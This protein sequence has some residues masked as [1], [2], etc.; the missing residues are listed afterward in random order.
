MADLAPCLG[1]VALA[2]RH[3]YGSVD[4]LRAVEVDV[5]LLPRNL[6]VENR[7]SARALEAVVGAAD[8]EDMAR[9]KGL[10]AYAEADCYV[11]D[12]FQDGHTGLQ[13]AEA[14]K[15]RLAYRQERHQQVPRSV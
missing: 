4:G 3:G 8:H 2:V 14:R 10:Q 6:A 5:V 7:H 13:Q 11:V 15:E 12:S 9:H 1:Q